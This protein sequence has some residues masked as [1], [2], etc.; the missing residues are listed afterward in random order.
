MNVLPIHAH[1]YYVFVSLSMPILSLKPLLEQSLELGAQVVLRGFV[2]DSHKATTYALQDL[3]NIS[4]YGFIVDPE[5]FIKYEIKQVPT[6]VV[7]GSDDRYDKL[8]GNISWNEAIN[9][10][11][12]LGDVYASE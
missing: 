7:V 8:S 1:E 4:K 3:I 9:I 10:M 2:N 6:F 12:R 11:K 5:L